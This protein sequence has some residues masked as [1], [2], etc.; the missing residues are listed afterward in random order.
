MSKVQ[1]YVIAIGA[2]FVFV[3]LFAL[4]FPVYLDA[5]DQ[6]GW[7][8]KCGNGFSAQLYQAATATNGTH[9]VAD[10]QSALLTRRAW[11]IPLVVVGSVGFFG[12]LMTS[13]LSSMRESLADSRT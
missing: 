11:T 12:V 3:G 9:F 1:W 5:F 7:Q 13:A 2:V 8:V 6:W 10:C 4:R